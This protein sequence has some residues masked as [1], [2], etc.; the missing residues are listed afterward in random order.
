MMQS[1]REEKNLQEKKQLQKDLS[2]L[3]KHTKIN[4]AF[5]DTNI[6]NTEVANINQAKQI[7]LKDN[8]HQIR[9]YKRG[10]LFSRSKLGNNT[11]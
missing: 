9:L 6:I 10:R 4:P 5:I 11:L 2:I 8:D 1:Y 7:P 3:S